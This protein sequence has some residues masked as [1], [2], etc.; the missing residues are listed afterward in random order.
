MESEQQIGHLCI[1]FIRFVSLFDESM[2]FIYIYTFHV[3]IAFAGVSSTVFWSLSIISSS[4][5]H[6]CHVSS[7]IGQL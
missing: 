6:A 1:G 2:N 4:V 7:A 5:M 3:H